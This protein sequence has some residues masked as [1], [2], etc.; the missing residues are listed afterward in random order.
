MRENV[1]IF[2]VG[3]AGINDVSFN[4]LLLG[5]IKNFIGSFLIGNP[6]LNCTGYKSYRVNVY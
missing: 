2:N 5:Y 1:P 3:Y 6:V 4:Y